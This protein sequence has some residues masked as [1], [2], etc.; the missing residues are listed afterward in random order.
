MYSLKNVL[1]ADYSADITGIEFLNNKFDPFDIK[2]DGWGEQLNENINDYD[3]IFGELYEKY[4]SKARMA[5]EIKL[6]FQLAGSAMMIH[7][8][9]TMF[10]SAIPSMDDIMRQN[11]EMM[12]QFTKAAAS[13][14]SNTSPNFSNFMNNMMPNVDSPLEMNGPTHA[15]D[16]S[17]FISSMK[18]SEVKTSEEKFVE[19]NDHNESEKDSTVSISELRNL[20]QLSPKKKGRRSKKDTVS[21]SL[22]M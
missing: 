20:S 19:V 9:N 13:S 6:M 15:P 3:D 16:I 1:R 17:E 5:P 21:I 10:K 4:K 11:P 12:Q 8:T 22:D 7:M 2:L 18:T 14:M